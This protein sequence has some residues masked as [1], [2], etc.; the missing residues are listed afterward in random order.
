MARPALRKDV[1][2]YVI[3]HYGLTMRRACRLVKQ[4][5]STQYYQSV[6]DPR[7]E[8][9]ARMREIAYTRVRYGYRR[10]HVLLR[11]EGWQ[12]GRDQAYRLYCE[13]QLQL[14][15]KLPKR[16]KMVVTRVQKIVP[17]KPNDAWSMDFVADQLADGSKFR[18]LTVVDVFTKE[19]L[20]IEV[21]QR[22]RGEHVVSA[23]NRIAVR[24]G[25]P[26]HIFVDNG[27]E[28]SGRL[29]DMWAYH[30][31]SKID[32]SRP[33]KPTDNCH[34]ETFNGSF[35]DECLN[36]HWF[37]TLDE[38]KATIEAWRGDYNESRP[39][40]ALKELAPAEFAR[41]LVFLPGPT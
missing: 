32:F 4:P 20:A 14:R 35:R 24:P 12:L 5:R 15:S 2:D 40:S 26:R 27:S 18:M 33:G 8:L 39:H 3:S 6:K 41:Q 37:E 21:G 31:K 17:S 9:R 11:R 22:L 28:F 38:A 23:L 19:A 7:A 30:H 29:L 13:E 25:A 16:R 34:I 36:L 1:V 10:V